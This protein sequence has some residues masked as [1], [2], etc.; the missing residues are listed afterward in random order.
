[1][2]QDLPDQNNR[3]I[4]GLKSKGF[5]LVITLALVSFVFLLVISLISQVRMDLAY[6]DV[7]QDHILAKAHARMGMMI[8][9]GEIQKHLGPDMRVSTTAD[10]YD[11]RIE[12]ERDYLTSSYPLPNALSESAQLYDNGT[13]RNRVELGQRQWTGVWKHRGGWAEKRLPT[14]PL[15]ENRDDGKALTLSWSYDS[16]YDPHPAIEQAWLVSGNEG[17]NRKLAM[18]DGVLVDEFIEV[19]DGII[20][21]DEGKRILND[22]LGGIYGQDDNPWMDHRKVVEDLN[23]S[24]LYH[25]PLMAIKDP[26][27][28]AN[29]NGSDKSVWLLKSPLLREEFDA[30]DPLDQQTWTDY[31][32]AEPVKVLKTALHLSDDQRD[33]EEEIDWGLRRGSYAYWVG[34]EGV[35]TKINIME[36]FKIEEG[37]IVDLLNEQNKLKVATEPNIEGGSFGFDFGSGSQKDDEQRKDLISPLSVKEL[38]EEGSSSAANVANHHYHS[39]TTDSFGVLADVRTGGLKRDLSLVFSLNQETSKAWKK[40]FAD[41]FIF[42][43]RVRAMKNIPL[44][45]NVKRNQWYVSANDA[46]VDDPDALL[47]GPPW[48]VLADFHNLEVFED[49]LVMEPP[50]QF[51]RTVGDNALIFGRRAPNS[52][53]NAFPNARSAYP[54]YNCFSSSVRKIRPE[55]KN[56]AIQPVFVKAR[57]SICPVATDDPGNFC[58]GIN[59]AI[60][61][62]NPYDKRMKVDNLFIEIPFAGEGGRYEPLECDITQV[63]FREYDLYRKWWAYMYADFNASFEL[64][65][66]DIDPLYRPYYSGYIKNWKEPWGIYNFVSGTNSFGEARFEEGLFDKFLLGQGGFKA[67]LGVNGDNWNNRVPPDSMLG[68]RLEGN[69]FYHENPRDGFGD[70]TFTFHSMEKKN[71]AFDRLILEVTSEEGS[72]E[73]VILEPGEVVTFAAFAS[74]DAAG[75]QTNQPVVSTPQPPE[76]IRVTRKPAGKVE[77]GYIWDSGFALDK[78]A[79]AFVIKMGGI[80]GYKTQTAEKFDAS[81]LLSSTNWSSVDGYIEPKC[82]TLWQGEPDLDSSQILSRITE[83]KVVIPDGG[84]SIK[85]STNNY[86]SLNLEETATGNYEKD[87]FGLGWEVSINMPGDLDNE[88][89][90]LVEFNTRALVHTTQHGQGNW[91]GDAKAKVPDHYRAPPQLKITPNPGPTSYSID[92]TLFAFNT[93]A[94]DYSPSFPKSTPDIYELPGARPDGPVPNINNSTNPDIR[95]TALG[96]TVKTTNYNFED[97]DNPEF[98]STPRVKSSWGQERIGFFTE[99]I[100]TTSPYTGKFSDSSH[101]VLFE[102]SAEKKLSIL[103][104]RHSNLNNYLHGPSYA[105]GNSY[106]STQVARHRSWGRVQNIVK[107]P[108]SEGGLTNIRQNLKDETDAI[109]Y[110]E[111]IFG[112]EIAGKKGLGNFINWDIDP[113]GGF[114]PWRDWGADQ[115]NHQNTTID[116]S[117]YLNAALLDGFLLSGSSTAN[118]YTRETNAMIGQRFRPYLWGALSGQVTNVSQDLN[119]SGNH[120][121]IG[122]FRNN[123]WEDAQTSYGK[124]SKEKG[125]STVND[126]D[127]RFQSVASDLLVDGAFNINSTS[128]DAWV[129]QL[130]SLRGLAVENANVG[131][132]E[133]PVIRFLEEP[134]ANDWNKL[135]VLT[136]SEIESLA[137]ALVKQVKLRGPFLSVADF[138]N[139]RLTLGPMDSDPSKARGTRVN[140]VQ[141]DLSEWNKYQEDRFTAQGLRGA[142]QSAIA[143]AGLNDPVRKVGQQLINNLSISSNK[144]TFDSKG[145]TV[146][147]G[148]QPHKGDFIPYIPA[149]R[150]INSFLNDSIFGLHA[151]SKL[152]ELY[153]QGSTRNWGVGSSTQIKEVV[154]GDVNG[155]ARIESVRDDLIS[156]PNTNFGEAPENLLAVEHLA[157]GANKPGWV[158]QADILSPLMP[159]TSARSDTFVIRVMGETNNDSPARAWAELV[160]QRTPDY[161]KSDLDAPHHRPHEPIKDINLN[162]YWDNG[163]NEHWID[164]NRNGD[165]QPQPD[166]PGVGELGKEKDYRDG[167]LSDLKLQMDPQEEDIESTSQISYQGINQRFGRKFKIIRFRWLREKDV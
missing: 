75:I 100:T 6:S 32:L 112:K 138:I 59:P 43:D 60:T 108:T 65:D 134:N 47:A 161:V 93:T 92:G 19:P 69:V 63:D 2:N 151:S 68:I 22:P 40:D 166:L 133:T 72:M 153:P 90:T 165:T 34:D 53:R 146:S 52:P 111:S 38:L 81:G 62:W 7:R 86:L 42:R 99:E 101:A 76:I 88:R 29:P 155:D 115:L 45:P 114:A 36:P 144:I 123:T 82:F 74:E 130:S 105:L 51:P 37:K 152:N 35:K 1:M 139:R 89:I 117:Y 78:D 107:R 20:I 39:M 142:V 50:D 121:L 8:A 110:Y 44:D 15:P 148:W 124:K 11:D 56:H 77:K 129:A 156:Y 66:S 162:G 140:F 79:C 159:V 120:R 164:L 163:L 30:N 102:V 135:R 137:K 18:M 116:H 48:S 10:I 27:G 3:P 83:P 160:V 96:F 122:Y 46:T 131:S 106:A 136:D 80:A 127:H 33:E 85:F 16:S 143:D 28:S 149:E 150:F 94:A 87:L 12:L 126:D 128:V 54:Y 97:S 49:T 158:M 119:I 17:W 23:S 84:S 118:D 13:N 167:F 95:A 98:L 41:N 24:R 4:V 147:N 91:L 104:Y 31:L 132:G 141:H 21:D 55:P 103:Q 125:Y 67:S 70:Y 109:K 157:T 25:H 58:L 145:T 113:D 61:L 14:P 26:L 73:P 154:V 57:L 71:I 9:I 5:A 64:K